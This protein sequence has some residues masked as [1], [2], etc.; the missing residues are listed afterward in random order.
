M[1]CV[2]PQSSRKHPRYIILK[3]FAKKPLSSGKAYMRA[4]TRTEILTEERRKKKK[5]KEKKRKSALMD[6]Y[7]CIFVRSST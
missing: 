6:L 5:E 7:V 2:S 4:Q 3:S 1:T